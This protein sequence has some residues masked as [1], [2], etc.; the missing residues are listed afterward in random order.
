MAEWFPSSSGS[1]GSTSWFG[2]SSS[3]SP[4]ASIDQLLAAQAARKEED[5]GGG[6]LGLL[7]NAW[8][9]VIGMAGGIG[10]LVAAGLH[11][12]MTGIGDI[13]DF[14]PGEG[15]YKLDDIGKGIVGFTDDGFH[16]MG[17]STMLGSIWDR[18]SPLFQG[19][20]DEFGD[21]LYEDPLGAVL[22]VASVASLG[23]GAAAKFGQGAKAASTVGRAGGLLDDLAQAG[24]RTRTANAAVTRA[25]LEETG[26]GASLAAKLLPKAGWTMREGEGLVRTS[27]AYN[28][29]Y[30][31]VAEP[32]KK[33]RLF[34]ESIDD[35]T[36]RS[37]QLKAVAGDAPGVSSKLLADAKLLDDTVADM[38][39]KGVKRIERPQIQKLYTKRESAM[40]ALNLSERFYN[41]RDAITAAEVAV[42]EKTLDAMGATRQTMRAS[43]ERLALLIQRLDIDV[44]DATVPNVIGLQDLAAREGNMS[45]ALGGVDEAI[46]TG[47]GGVATAVRT[48]PEADGTV[49]RTRAAQ[50]KIDEY[51]SDLET[52]RAERIEGGWDVDGAIADALEYKDDLEAGAARLLDPEVSADFKAVDELRLLEA[53]RL[54]G[55][56]MDDGINGFMTGPFTPTEI[57]GR[58]YRPLQGKY[59]MQWS[60]E[61]DDYVFPEGAG[62]DR[63]ALSD[64]LRRENQP[65]PVYLPHI[66]ANNLKGSALFRSRAKVGANIY[67]ADPHMKQMKLALLRNGEWLKDPIEVIK[68]RGAS[69]VRESET[70]HT[71][72]AITE[73]YGLELSDASELPTGFQLVAP[74]I[75]FANYRVRSSFLNHIDENLTR[76]MGRDSAVA[77]A[78]KDTLAGQREL[79]KKMS[80]AGQIKMY[81]VPDSVLKNLDA[82][83][84][85]SPVFGG[86]GVQLYYD[87][88]MNMWRG[89][90]LTASPRWVVN[91]VLGNIA[92]GLMQGVK[93]GDVVRIGAEQFRALLAEKSELFGPKGLRENT[94]A[95]QVARLPGYEDV[96]SKQGFFQNRLEN[97]KPHLPGGAEDMPGGKAIIALKES[98][99][100][101]RMHNMGQAVKAFNG[102]IEDSFRTASFLTAA[103]KAMGKGVVKRT[104]GQFSKSFD[105]I[106]DIMEHGFDDSSGGLARLKLT[107]DEVGRFYGNYGK[108]TPFERHVIRR[109]VFPFWGFYRHSTG[110]MLRFPFEYPGRAHV[111]ESL[112]AVT[113]DMLEEYGPM[114]EWM[115]SPMPM[116]PPG[117]E[118][119]ILSGAGANPFAGPGEGIAGLGQMFSPL[120]KTGLEQ[121]TGRNIFTGETFTDRDTFTPFGSDQAYDINSLEP[122][123]KVAPGVLQALVSQ[124]P[125]FDMARDLIAGGNTYDTASLL[126][127][128]QQRMGDSGEASPVDPETG[129]PYYDVTAS[130]QLAKLFGVN[131]FNY[132]LDS[133]AERQQQDQMAVLR[134]A[135]ERGVA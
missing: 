123:D 68:R 34:S 67:A 37:A 105:R 84:K 43:K 73:R 86:K 6:I 106:T 11:D 92:F 31:A 102:T 120:I 45:L 111:L 97:Y 117:G 62:V 21:N 23:A 39:A 91:N 38:T 85:W 119:P 36:R 29:L 3:S 93:T 28:P 16:P 101:T 52:N 133:F 22:D 121:A 72:K 100:S 115:R 19:K 8:E 114:P 26:E 44:E 107:A 130:D 78:M 56:T 132:D 118:V 129:E 63:K 83:A 80:E 66:D 35:L 60:D 9:G 75:L 20:L 42:V 58:A 71:W 1:S 7:G 90:A 47:G 99:A 69:A 127:A 109:F 59:G 108:M 94:L 110:L 98:R 96:V 49:M 104:V 122:V 32:I 51:I 40:E 70:F 18:W 134:E 54:S 12:T 126:D 4:S 124:V 55:S 27:Q 33:S 76:G 113:A 128:L 103:E 131:V 77:K 57:L 135:L 95:G 17:D 13:A 53:E 81:A 15:D 2:S 112:E 116:G 79:V 10:S 48:L 24:V 87:T 50:T 125:Q 65:A 46:P 25:A 89:L 30:R 61:V 64:A 5:S 74:D 41:R 82:A 88:V 14:N